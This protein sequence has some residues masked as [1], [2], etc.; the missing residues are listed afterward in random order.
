MNRED[1]L[2]TGI[3]DY[4]NFREK[5]LDEKFN[6]PSEFLPEKIDIGAWRN[7]PIPL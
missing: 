3:G 7:I 4:S 6:L 5:M 1:L 2:L